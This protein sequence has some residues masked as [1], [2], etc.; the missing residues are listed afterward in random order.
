MRQPWVFVDLADIQVSERSLVSAEDWGSLAVYPWS[1][2]CE[3]V[4]TNPG[5]HELFTLFTLTCSPVEASARLNH[6][7]TR[8]LWNEPQTLHIY[9]VVGV[10]DL[11]VVPS[12]AKLRWNQDL[13]DVSVTPDEQ[14]REL[15]MSLSH[16][17]TYWMQNHAC[18][19][20]DFP[21]CFIPEQWF[22]KNKF[23]IIYLQCCHKSKLYKSGSA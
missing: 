21:V 6:S 5:H 4:P 1:R 10:A 22:L 17:C 11:S 12:E 2:L 23:L 18:W 16:T 14:W 20:H 15:L 8:S 7:E 19:W 13:S 9:K 3:C